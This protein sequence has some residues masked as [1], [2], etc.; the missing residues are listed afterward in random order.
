[1]KELAVSWKLKK[2]LTIIDCFDFADEKKQN[3][4][5]FKQKHKDTSVIYGWVNKNNHMVYIGSADE[6]TNRPF[7]HTKKHR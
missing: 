2:P 3:L 1:L 5:I 4:T 7:Q 6:A